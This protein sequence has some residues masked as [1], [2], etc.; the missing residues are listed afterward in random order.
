MRIPI[1]T[2]ALFIMFGALAVGCQKEGSVT[3]MQEMKAKTVEAMYT[4]HYTV[5]DASY[6]ATLG[7]DEALD[8]L[9]LD[10]LAYARE[11]YT[12][13]LYEETAFSQSAGTRETV[14]FQTQDQGQ[15]DA[16]VR[17]KTAQGY[18]VT[19]TYDEHSGVYTC[20]AYR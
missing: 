8:S 3:P 13:T 12:V 7:S 20:T 15:A 17:T 11:G 6:I 19:M 16:W 1:R 14:V 4:I 18:I 10:L 9:L 2:L 5:G